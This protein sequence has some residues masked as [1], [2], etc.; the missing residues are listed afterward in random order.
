MEM[1][2]SVLAAVVG[3]AVAMAALP[4][5]AQQPAADKHACASADVVR[6]VAVLH[7]TRGNDARGTVTFTQ[8]GDKVRVSAVVRGLKPNS[9]HGFHVHQFGDCTAMDG[10]SAGGHYNPTGDPHAGPHDNERHAGDFGNLTSN[11]QGVARLDLTVDNISVG[12]GPTMILGRGVIVHA[13]PDDLVSQPTGAAGARIA[14][15]VIGVAKDGEDAEA[16]A[17][18]RAAADMAHG[19]S[20]SH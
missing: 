6:A 5:A 11:G 3:T 14:C 19:H 16:A 2:K 9:K 17:K 8:V 12:C 15:G 20:E 10:T 4:A 18:N 7:P 1:R 13:D